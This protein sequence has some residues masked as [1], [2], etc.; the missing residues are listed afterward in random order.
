MDAPNGYFNVG[1]EDLEDRTL[2]ELAD[3]QSLPLRCVGIDLSG[4][5]LSRINLAGAHFE[6]CILTG[7]DL[8]QPT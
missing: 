4:Q 1:P 7:A 8:P 6:R 5:D 2:A 3:L